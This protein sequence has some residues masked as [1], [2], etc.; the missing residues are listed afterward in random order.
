[1]KKKFENQQE[2]IELIDEYHKEIGKILEEIE[3][4]VI[5]ADHLRNT[6]EAFRIEGLR[7]KVETMHRQIEWRSGRLETLK[8]VLAELR[9]Q[10]LPFGKLNN[11]DGTMDAAVTLAQVVQP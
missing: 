4:L 2:A 9:T 8:E 3:Q 10:M 1:M 5:L 7:A 6:M 11:L